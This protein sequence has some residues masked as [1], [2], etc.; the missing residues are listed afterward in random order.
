MDL[1]PKFSIY[2]KKVAMA[3][4]IF[5]VVVLTQNVSAQKME[6]ED[7]QIEGMTIA[8]TNME[9]MLSFYAGIFNIKFI[10]KDINGFKL[11]KGIWGGF[12]VL[13]CPHLW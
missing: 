5:F 9:A 13:F 1:I 12:N 3:L 7:Y 6:K 11:Y 4:G 8:I 2:N 10:E